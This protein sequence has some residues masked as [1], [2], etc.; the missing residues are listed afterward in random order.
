MTPV[1][2]PMWFYLLQIC[3]ILRFIS[4]FALVTFFFLGSTLSV[5]AAVYGEKYAK[6]CIII[7]VVGIVVSSLIMIFFPSEETLV[8]MKASEFVT[9][10]NLEAA[11]TTL[12]DM[13]SQ[14]AS[15]IK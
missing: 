14:I 4:I 15:M 3:D 2:S 6:T 13:V 12:L 9:P 1:I 8:A 7:T 10:D 5:A 11:K